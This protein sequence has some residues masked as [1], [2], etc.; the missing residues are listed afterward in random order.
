M[1]DGDQLDSRTATLIALE[2]AR[3]HPLIPTSLQTFELFDDEAHDDGALEPD[4]V[5]GNWLD[6]LTRHEG[7]FTF[8]AR[9]E[10]GETV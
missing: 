1:L 4:G 10:F 2:Q 7:H 8:R 5:Y 3:G 6:D 9:A